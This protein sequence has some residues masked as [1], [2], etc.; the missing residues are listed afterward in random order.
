MLLQRWN[1]CEPPQSARLPVALFRVLDEAE[2]KI[3]IEINMNLNFKSKVK[4]KKKELAENLH[5]AHL[6]AMVLV[7]VV[8][9]TSVLDYVDWVISFSGD[10]ML[11]KFSYFMF[12]TS[13]LFPF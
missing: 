7:F 3:D 6:L 1:K 12:M 9:D 13:Q 11:I 10:F 2:R 5:L 4:R 8:D